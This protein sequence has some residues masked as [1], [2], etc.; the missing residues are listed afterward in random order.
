MLQACGFRIYGVWGGGVRGGGGGRGGGVGVGA[1]AVAVEIGL[2]WVL[3]KEFVLSYQ[4]G[5]YSK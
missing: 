3:V 5:V 1:L 2:P 4:I